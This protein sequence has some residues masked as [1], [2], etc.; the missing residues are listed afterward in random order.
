M[1]LGPNDMVLSYMSM[2]HV[3][4]PWRFFGAS[5]E[6][7]CIAAAAGG[8]AG[9]GIV[10]VVYDE[11]REAG[12]SDTDLRAMLSDRGLVLAELE[13]PVPLPALSEKESVQPILDHTLEIADLFGAERVLLVTGPGL[14]EEEAAEVFGWGCDRCA[15]HGLPATMEYVSNTVHTSVCDAA[16]AVRVVRAADRANGGI[17]VDSYHHF[18]G[19]DDWAE[20]ESIPGELVGA[21]QFDDTTIPRV[22]PN[23]VEGTPHHRMA[24]GEGDADLVRFVRTLDAIGANVPYSIEVINEEIVKL[25]PTALGERLG[26]TTR[27]VFDLA[28]KGDA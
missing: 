13:A 18:N 7:R 1:A 6:D 4:P 5:F 25:P 17:T 28:R 22:E 19:P 14:S 11:A 16:T 12:H 9:I 15:E 26:S 21:I 23:W 10:P 3:E 27:K 8:F 20:L 2:T 24:P